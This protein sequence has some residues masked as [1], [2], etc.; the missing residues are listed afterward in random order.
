MKVAD[1]DSVRKETVN[2]ASHSC[3]RPRPIIL[4]TSFI[5]VSFSLTTARTI[6][7]TDSIH[8]SDMVNGSIH[9]MA[10]R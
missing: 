4:I 8:P 1:T 7:P 9:S 6:I 2:H 5:L 3:P 10:T